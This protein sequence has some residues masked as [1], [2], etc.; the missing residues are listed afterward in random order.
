M[1]A[2]AGVT[3]LSRPN[4]LQQ[5]AESKYGH[6]GG[7]LLVD[8]LNR[9]VITASD[10]SQVM[11]KVPDAGINPQFDRFINGGEGSLVYTNQ[12]GVEVLASA[13]RIEGS[14]WFVAVSLPT[15]E[16]FASIREMQRR[17]LWTTLA[18]AGGR[19]GELAD[20]AK[21][22]EALVSTASLLADMSEERTSLKPLPVARDDEI[23]ILV[24]GF[25]S[26]A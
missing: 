11:R 1:V 12:L 4:F 5:V 23:G 3:D 19:A 22:A 7:Y 18:D 13:K 17:M 24:A 21:D 20:A 15:E 2:F 10:K 8:R 14:E 9:L 6:S 26:L 16:A 25:Q